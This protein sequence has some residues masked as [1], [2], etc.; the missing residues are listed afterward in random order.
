[1]NASTF[2]AVIRV[3]RPDREEFFSWLWQEFGQAGLLGIHEG[4][5][6]S[7]DAARSGLETES[8][9]IDAGEAPRD[10]DWI[11]AQAEAEV[12]LYF[13]DREAAVQALMRIRNEADDVDASAEP[14][15][16][17]AQDWDAEWKASFRGIDV[18]PF[19][20][21]R[22]PWVDEQPDGKTVILRLNPGA[23]FGTG[24][25]ET[26][27]LCLEALAGVRGRKV[28]DFGS[29][30]G[31]LSIAAK[32]LGADKV[33][34]V[35]IDPLANDNARENAALN[36]VT[37][38]FMLQMPAFSEREPYD[39]VLAN[40]LKPVLLEFVDQLVAR[41]SSTGTMILSGLT[42]PDV[43]PVLERYRAA[44]SAKFGKM[45]NERVSAL[46]EWRSIVLKI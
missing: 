37:P 41:L 36:G 22:P 5:L 35:E 43:Q 15:E 9:T 46:N 17:K 10:R 14:F 7:E 8:W 1:M 25:H 11:A 19:W 6:L 4:T 32:L 38:E 13:A 21:I 34:G 16:Q 44:F 3:K 27:Q 45:P 20:K 29:G 12:A 39:V 2:V 42:E 28:L 26:T 40:I 18:S 30:S 24:T 23:G 31:I 33:D